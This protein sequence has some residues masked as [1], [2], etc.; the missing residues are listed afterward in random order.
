MRQVGWLEPRLYTVGTVYTTYSGSAFDLGIDREDSRLD[1]N[2][3]NEPKL[4]KETKSGSFFKIKSSV[5]DD[6]EGC[7]RR[8]YVFA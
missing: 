1:K 4:P 7:R 5:S 2:D 6:P 3:Q 8:K